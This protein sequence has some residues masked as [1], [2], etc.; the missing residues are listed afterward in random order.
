MRRSGHGRGDASVRRCDTGIFPV[1]AQHADLLCQ[2]LVRP[3]AAYAS[4]D[5]LFRARRALA[6]EPRAPPDPPFGASAPS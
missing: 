4:V 1:C 5:K 3:F 2:H 6:A